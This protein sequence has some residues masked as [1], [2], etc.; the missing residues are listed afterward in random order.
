M[1]QVTGIVK[2]YVNGALYRSKPGAKLK[3]GGKKREAVTGHSVYGFTEEVEAAELD[4]TLAHMADTN[5]PNINAIVGATL[6]FETDTGQ[7]LMVAN[8]FTSEPCEISSGGDLSL[9]MMGDPAI[10]EG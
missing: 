10:D 5:V 9:K 2:I 6:R 7:T 8:A 1:A 4:A 3:T